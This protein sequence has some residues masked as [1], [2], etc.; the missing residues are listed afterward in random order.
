VVSITDALALDGVLRKAISQGIPLIA[1][2]T[3]DLRDPAARIPYLT[4]VGTDYYQDG[5]KAGEHALAHA[6]AGEIPMPKQVLCAN[7]D[8]THGGLVA[9]CKGMTDAM[10]TAGIKTET[11]ATDLDSE[12]VSGKESGRELHLCGDR[13]FGPDGLDRL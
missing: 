8:A 7:A 13:R 5:K 6:K 10:K 4:F 2:N 12:C 9:R 3:P 1:F 11:L